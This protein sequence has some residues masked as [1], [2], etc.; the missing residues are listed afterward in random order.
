[1]TDDR[2]TKHAASEGT[3]ESPCWAILDTFHPTLNHGKTPEV[4]SDNPCFEGDPE[5]F[6]AWCRQHGAD[7]K[8]YAV[9]PNKEVSGGRSTSAALAGYQ[10]MQNV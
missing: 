6:F 2:Q 10:E 4:R 1:M 5:L 3:S 7:G 8:W 9:T